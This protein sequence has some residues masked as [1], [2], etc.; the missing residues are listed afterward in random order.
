MYVCVC[1]WKWRLYTGFGL[2]VC[3]CVCVCVLCMYVCMYVCMY[4]LC[5][6]VFI[7]HVCICIFCMYVFVCIFCM[8]VFMC[9]HALY[10]RLYLHTCNYVPLC[11]SRLYI[12]Q[13]YFIQ[14]SILHFF[15]IIPV[16]NP[17]CVVLAIFGNFYIPEDS[18]IPELGLPSFERCMQPVTTHC[19]GVWSRQMNA[20]L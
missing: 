17:S 11:I 9:K 12:S 13:N 14:S 4:L 18:W 10:N 6:Y 5:M 2:T 7:V 19:P 3:V 8:Y 15:W 16:W 20:L 1:V